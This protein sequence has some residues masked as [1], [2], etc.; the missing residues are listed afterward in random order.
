MLQVRLQLQLGWAILDLKIFNLYSGIRI[1]AINRR[2][3]K[4]AKWISQLEAELARPTIVVGTD[5]IDLHNMDR[6]KEE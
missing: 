1:W 3:D 6:M 2:R 4:L 5:G